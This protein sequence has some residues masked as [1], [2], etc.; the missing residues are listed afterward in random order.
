MLTTT[1]CLIGLIWICLRIGVRYE[2]I[3]FV[4]RINLFHIY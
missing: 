1:S 3:T 2:V 4:I